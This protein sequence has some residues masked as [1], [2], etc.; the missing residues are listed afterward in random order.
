MSDLALWGR[1]SFVVLYRRSDNKIKKVGGDVSSFP[2]LV[3]LYIDGSEKCFFSSIY[4]DLCNRIKLLLNEKLLTR[5]AGYLLLILQWDFPL[6]LLIWFLFSCLRI[7][8]F[9]IRKLHSGLL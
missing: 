3:V 8:E 7:L 1:P 4:Y 5:L 6:L 9:R 2:L